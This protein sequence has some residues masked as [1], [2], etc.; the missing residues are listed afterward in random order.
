MRKNIIIILSVI[1]L[2][3]S[4]S[5][6]TPEKKAEVSK[7]ETASATKG[8]NN[9]P[10]GFTDPQVLDVYEQYKNVLISYQKLP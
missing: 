4:N 10:K 9:A 7:T 2:A 1:L 8:S 3:C 6:D 5:T